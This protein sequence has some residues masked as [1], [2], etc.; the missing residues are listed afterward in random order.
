MYRILIVDDEPAGLNHV[1]MI[2]QKKCPQYK[3]IGSANNGKEALDMIR[4]DQPDVL[5]TDIRMPVMNGI[6]FV[7]LVK[8]EFPSI[9]AVIVS[10]YSEFEYAKSALKFGVCDYLLKPLVPSDMQKIMKRGTIF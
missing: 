6:E 10:G 8:Q 4:R 7:E 9:L 3:I 1:R 2:L 5:I